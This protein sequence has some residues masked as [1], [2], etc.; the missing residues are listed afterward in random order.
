MCG[1]L[2]AACTICRHDA[3][4]S[5]VDIS[6]ESWFMSSA[7][8]N[9]LMSS[10]RIKR[11]GGYIGVIL[12][13]DKNNIEKLLLSC[14]CR[15][16]RKG[17]WRE[18]RSQQMWSCSMSLGPLKQGWLQQQWRLSERQSENNLQM[19]SRNCTISRS[20]QVRDPWNNTVVV[21]W[22]AKDCKQS[23]TFADDSIVPSDWILCAFCVDTRHFCPVSWNA[24]LPLRPLIYTWK[25]V[26]KH[27]GNLAILIYH[28]SVIWRFLSTN[29]Q[30]S[31]YGSRIL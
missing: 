30:E 17:I 24:G 13:S 22:F 21:L 12:D 20:H 3:F 29:V 4:L 23:W 2:K 1:D 9:D 25:H 19:I 8:S 5:K 27:N 16:E 18:L 31:T 26:C 28:V 7:L 6:A 11:K 15:W 10:V 14:G